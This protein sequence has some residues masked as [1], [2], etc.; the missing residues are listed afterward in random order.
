MMKKRL[1]AISEA[2]E[3]MAFWKRNQESVARLR[4]FLPGLKIENG[5]HYGEILGSIYTTRLQ[6][7]AEEK[8]S[9]E[10]NDGGQSEDKGN[11][12]HKKNETHAE[13]AGSVSELSAPS[14]PATKPLPSPNKRIRDK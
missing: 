7:F 4:E 13:N 9:N 6:K 5:K 14:R 1:E 3:F 11:G 12:S 2:P 10:H 8:A